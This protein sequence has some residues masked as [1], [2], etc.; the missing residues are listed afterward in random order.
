MFVI[1]LL[2]VFEINPSRQFQKEIREKRKELSYFDT[3]LYVNRN[4]ITIFFF[5]SLNLNRRN[6]YISAYAACYIDF[7][8][9]QRCRSFITKGKIYKDIVCTDQNFFLSRCP[10]L[11]NVHMREVSLYCKYIYMYTY[12]YI[13]IYVYMYI[14]N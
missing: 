14:W 7:V 5:F 4:L 1:C 10:N 11:L 2:Y 6:M 13:Y 8:S 12:I 3:R 9:F